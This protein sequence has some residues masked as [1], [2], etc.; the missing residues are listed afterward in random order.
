AAKNGFQEA[1]LGRE[2]LRT[3]TAVIAALA[4]IRYAVG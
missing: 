2:I 1:S 3:E 4:V